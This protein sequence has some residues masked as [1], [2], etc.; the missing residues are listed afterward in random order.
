MFWSDKNDVL[1]VVCFGRLSKDLL[2]I[3]FAN[4]VPKLEPDLNESWCS[5]KCV[6]KLRANFQ[7]LLQRSV[8]LVDY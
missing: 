6:I 2:S 4:N 7:L 8:N 5:N 3:A 1:E